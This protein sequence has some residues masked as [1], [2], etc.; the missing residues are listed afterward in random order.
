MKDNNLYIFKLSFPCWFDAVFLGRIYMKLISWYICV[1]KIYEITAHKE[2][3]DS[4]SLLG[5]MSANNLPT[6]VVCYQIS[7]VFFQLGN[8][9]HCNLNRSAWGR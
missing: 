3:I 1:S 4:I 6:I 8:V 5:H 9:C 2:Y 7:W